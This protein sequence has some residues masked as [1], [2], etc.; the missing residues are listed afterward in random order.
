MTADRVKRL[1]R[2]GATGLKL[3]AN[4]LSTARFYVKWKAGEQ[5]EISPRSAAAI[6][7]RGSNP[8]LE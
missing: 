6:R 7:G 3:A 4:S 2:C 1:S 8:S 5:E